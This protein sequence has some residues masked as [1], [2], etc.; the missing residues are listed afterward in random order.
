MGAAAVE[1]ETQLVCSGYDDRERLAQARHRLGHRAAHGGDD[2]DRVAQQLLVQ[3]VGVA[4]PVP[5]PG[6][7]V[8]GLVAEVAGGPVHQRELPL[9]AQRGLR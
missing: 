8:R 5:R 9:D 4:Q 6:E 7:E 3:P 2:L 1:V